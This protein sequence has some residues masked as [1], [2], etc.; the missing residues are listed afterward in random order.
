MASEYWAKRGP[1]IVGPLPTREEALA[2][3]REK[4]PFRHPAWAASAPRHQILTGYGAGGPW[5]D[6]RWHDAIER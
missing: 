6:M 2:A 4:H 1:K 3:F 5:F